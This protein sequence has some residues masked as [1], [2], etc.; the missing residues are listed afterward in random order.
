MISPRTRFILAYLSPAVLIYG[1]FVGLPL[2]QSFY[3]AMFRWKGVSNR[4]TFVG[5]KNFVQMAQDRTLHTAG[6]NQ[7]LL[8]SLGGFFLVVFGV[9]IAHALQNRTRL[10]RTVQAIMLF[11]QVISM[12]MVG[13]IW[14]FMWNPSFGLLSKGAQALSIPLPKS[15]VLG[16]SGWASAAV[17]IAFLW[18]AIGFYV[19]LF[20]AGISGIDGEI[21]EASK[22]DG[23][24]GWTRFQKITWP[25]LW[26][27]KR[28][29]MVYVVSNVMGTFV[30]VRLLTNS[31]PDNATQVLLTYIY[32]K[33][34]EQSQMGQAATV[35]VYSFL[36]AM[37]LGS[38]AMFVVG[39]N[40][41]ARRSVEA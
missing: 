18:H 28:I 31:G 41:E 40:P 2:V 21:L 29:A 16:V 9:T 19:M 33:G 4:M 17:L 6:M 8:L 32:Q 15:G 30:L 35:A 23:A 34:W 1:L 11:P 36:I 12:V 37:L 3:Y 7:F 26:S 39:K 10:S 5:S 20:S 13:I 38:L 27:I 14:Q 25:L 24:S 22:L